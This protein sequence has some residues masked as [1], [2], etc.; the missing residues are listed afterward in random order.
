MGPVLL[1]LFMVAVFPIGLFL[2]GALVSG[3]HGWWYTDQ[4]EKIHAGTEMLEAS[5]KL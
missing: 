4:A 1:I 2:S 5:K 3:L